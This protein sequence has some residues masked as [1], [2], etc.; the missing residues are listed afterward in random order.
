M[1][2]SILFVPFVITF[3]PFVVKSG[4]T[5]K[6]SKE[7]TKDSRRILKYTSAF[8]ARRASSSIENAKQ[9]HEFPV[10]GLTATEE[11][12]LFPTG[13]SASSNHCFY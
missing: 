11:E 2:D 7:Y 8:F 6:V 3:G 4:F 1:G 13:K 12:C 5:T 9:N 10:M